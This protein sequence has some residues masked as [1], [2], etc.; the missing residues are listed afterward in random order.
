MLSVAFVCSC[1]DRITETVVDG[2]RG[3]NLDEYPTG[4]AKEKCRTLQ[5]RAFFGVG[6]GTI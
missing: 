2:S 1:V 4:L 6:Y 3:N 5:K